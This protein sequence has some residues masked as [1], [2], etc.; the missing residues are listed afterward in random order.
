VV[1][2][3]HCFGAQG[4]QSVCG[5]LSLSSRSQPREWLASGHLKPAAPAEELIAS[6]EAKSL[7][8]TQTLV[9]IGDLNMCIIFLCIFSSFH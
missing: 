8:A 2:P 5:L 7:Y 4:N 6:A 9:D 3:W 1:Y